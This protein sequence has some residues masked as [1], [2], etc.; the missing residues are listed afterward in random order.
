MST[1]SAAGKSRSSASLRAVA[2][3]SSAVTGG[4]P[5]PTQVS[6][7]QSVQ[8]QSTRPDG[9]DDAGQRTTGV[10]AVHVHDDH[11]AC[12][13]GGVIASPC[14]TRRTIVAADE[15]VQSRVSTVQVHSF[16]PAEVA[17]LSSR[18]V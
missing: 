2:S 7:W 10:L 16:I 8:M 3:T 15:P 1:S 14:A 5:W 13:T 9:V 6:A 11:A 4:G 18:A 17:R 12:R